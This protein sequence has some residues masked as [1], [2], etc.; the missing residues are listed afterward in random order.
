ML[1]QSSGKQKSFKHTIVV[2]PLQNRNVKIIYVK[3]GNW[4]PK[5]VFS[6]AAGA[7]SVVPTSEKV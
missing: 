6:G 7:W 4:P 1:K 2:T 5:S 3:P